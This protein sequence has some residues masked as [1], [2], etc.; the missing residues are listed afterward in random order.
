MDQ[1]MLFGAWFWFL[2]P[3]IGTCVWGKQKAELPQPFRCRH[4]PCFRSHTCLEHYDG[5]FMSPNHLS[6]ILVT[7]T[8]TLDAQITPTLTIVLRDDAFAITFLWL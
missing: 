3:D 7:N 4:S 5:A 6:T 2:F 1:G 8:L